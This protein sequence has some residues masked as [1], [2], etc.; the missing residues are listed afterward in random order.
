MSGADVIDIQDII[1]D[2]L[3]KIF[4][5]NKKGRPSDIPHGGHVTIVT[6]CCCTLVCGPFLGVQMVCLLIRRLS[7]QQM[8]G[9]LV[10]GLS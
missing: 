2:L 4:R 10:L 1:I 6:H 7:P 8:S 9:R 5:L 3:F